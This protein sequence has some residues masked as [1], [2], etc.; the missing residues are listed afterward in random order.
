M[1]KQAL[2]IDA[3]LFV[4]HSGIFEVAVNGR[5]VAKREPHGFPTEDEIVHAVAQALGR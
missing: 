1:L 5:V 3:Q 4:G 2:D